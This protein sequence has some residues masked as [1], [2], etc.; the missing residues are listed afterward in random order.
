MIGWIALAAAAQAAPT[1][2]PVK[3]DP[4]QAVVSGHTVTHKAA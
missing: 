2:T 4:P 3:V 1:A